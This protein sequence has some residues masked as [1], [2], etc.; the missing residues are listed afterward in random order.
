MSDI[1]HFTSALDTAAKW[2]RTMLK[3][4]ASLPQLMLPIDNKEARTNLVEY[5]AAGCPKIFTAPAPYTISGYGDGRNGKQLFRDAGFRWVW[6]E[7]RSFV[8]NEHFPVTASFDDVDFEF[9]EFSHDPSTDEVLAEFKRLGLMRPT[10]EDALRFAIK[11]PEEQRK[12]P[13]IFFHEPWDAGLGHLPVLFLAKSNRG[14]LL[15]GTH[16]GRSWDRECRFVAR[17]PRN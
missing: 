14:Q 10:A 6:D 4:G 8:E 16:F 5:L 3:A 15:D 13:L 11:Y 7:A 12:A 17:R 9:V 1:A 2:F